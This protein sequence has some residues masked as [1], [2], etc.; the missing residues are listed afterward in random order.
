MTGLQASNLGH[1]GRDL[2]SRLPV[3][4]YSPTPGDPTVPLCNRPAAAHITPLDHGQEASWTIYACAEHADLAIGDQTWDWHP[5]AVACS[6]R[7]STWVQGTA[8]HLSRCALPRE[9]AA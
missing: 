3:C 9:Q 7:G 1:T 2:T 6:A 8:F 4:G 5:L